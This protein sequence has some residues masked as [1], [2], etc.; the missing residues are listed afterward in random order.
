M[1]LA[2][3]GKIEKILDNDP[4]MRSGEVDFGGVKKEV[5]LAFV[6]DAKEGDFVI[7][8]VGFAI[9]MVDEEE[10][11][12]IFGYLKEIDELDELNEDTE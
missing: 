11:K 8:H 4:I 9:S 5:N 7:V 6:E 12:K 3:P 10:A 2:I 1:C